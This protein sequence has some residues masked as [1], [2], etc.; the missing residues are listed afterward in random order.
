MISADLIVLNA[1]IYTV[2]SGH[3]QALAVRDG[4]ILAVGSTAEIRKLAGPRTKIEDLGARLCSPA[5]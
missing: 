2:S 5:S 4:K 3:A 1:N